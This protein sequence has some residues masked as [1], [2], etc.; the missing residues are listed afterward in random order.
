MYTKTRSRLI[1]GPED[2]NSKGAAKQR[3]A[4]AAR[5]E[6]RCLSE[7]VLR[8]HLDSERVAYPLHGEVLAHALELV[9]AVVVVLVRRLHHGQRLVQHRLRPHLHAA[10]TTARQH[11]QPRR[12]GATGKGK[13]MTAHISQISFVGILGRYGLSENFQEAESPKPSVFASKAS[14]LLQLRCAHEPKGIRILQ[15]KP[16]PSAFRERQ[17]FWK[18]MA[19]YRQVPPSVTTPPFSPCWGLALP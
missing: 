3:S 6:K 2:D 4:G 5:I 10:P 18:A 19:D 13:H 16:S 15:M 12:E 9:A 1:H 7:L 14:R 11:R 8:P 17:P